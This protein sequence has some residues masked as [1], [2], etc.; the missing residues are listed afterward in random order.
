MLVASLSLGELRL[1]DDADRVSCHRPATF[2]HAIKSDSLD[3]QQK[4]LQKPISHQQPSIILIYF[5]LILTTKIC[6]CLSDLRTPSSSNGEGA[7]AGACSGTAVQ[8]AS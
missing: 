5:V 8:N 1:S 7:A 4:T 6:L 3:Q 2:R